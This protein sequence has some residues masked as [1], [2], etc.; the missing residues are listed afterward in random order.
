MI[1]ISGG[2]NWRFQ[3]SISM[4]LQSKQR[5]RNGICGFGP[6]NNG[7]IAKKWTRREVG[8]GVS[9]LPLSLPLF[10]SPLFLRGLSLLQKNT[11]TVATQAKG[12]YIQLSCLLKGGS[13]TRLLT[14][15]LT[16][17]PSVFSQGA[18]KNC[19]GLSPLGMAPIKTNFQNLQVQHTP[20]KVDSYNIY[21]ITSILFPYLMTREQ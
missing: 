4:R 7:T 1:F 21:I 13:I 19:L 8:V 15:S 3:A 18:D 12:P 10:Y 6:M 2:F 20:F 14:V 16:K 17:S 5:P 11:E 9:L